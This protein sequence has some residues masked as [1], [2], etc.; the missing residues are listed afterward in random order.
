MKLGKIIVFILYLGGSFSLY[1]SEQPRNRSCCMGFL[2]NFLNNYCDKEN[3]DPTKFFQSFAAKAF[4]PVFKSKNSAYTEITY[5]M[6]KRL[7]SNTLFQKKEWSL[8]QELDSQGLNQFPDTLL[9]FTLD[10]EE[11]A[12]RTPSKGLKANCGII[13]II[14]AL[15]LNGVM[16]Q[17]SE[18]ANNGEQGVD[19]FFR[20]YPTRIGLSKWRTHSF[21]TVA[22]LPLAVAVSMGSGAFSIVGATFF[23]SVGFLPPLLEKRW[24]FLG[25]LPEVLVNDANEYCKDNNIPTS[26]VHQK[27]P[28]IDSLEQFLRQRGEKLLTLLVEGHYMNI[29]YINNENILVDCLYKHITILTLKELKELLNQKSKLKAKAIYGFLLK[30]FQPKVNFNDIHFIELKTPNESE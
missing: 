20:K 23:G 8:L 12:Q 24:N 22:A 18:Y 21:A 11:Y 6:L 3:N 2:Y 13:A 26:F 25:S 29:K 15:R 5:A 4:N 7:W 16:P 27:L 28:S 30:A 1:S 14:K 9:T 10:G 17:F 19:N